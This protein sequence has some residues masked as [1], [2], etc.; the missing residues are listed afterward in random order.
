MCS[1]TQLQGALAVGLVNAC[2]ATV[3]SLV[4]H[5]LFCSQPGGQHCLTRWLAGSA[6][7]VTCGAVCWV[8]AGE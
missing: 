7:V 5:A 3:V 1:V 2:R 6:V 4:T 8:N